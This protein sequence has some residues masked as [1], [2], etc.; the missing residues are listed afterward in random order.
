MTKPPELHRPTTAEFTTALAVLDYAE[1]MRE[2][3][4]TGDDGIVRVNGSDYA[5]ARRALEFSRAFIVADPEE[6]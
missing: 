1:A 5:A 4:S 2:H 6:L 3:F